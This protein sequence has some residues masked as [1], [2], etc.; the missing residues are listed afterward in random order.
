MVV[1]PTCTK[2]FLYKKKY[3]A[4]LRRGVFIK[5]NVFITLLNV[6]LFIINIIIDTQKA[7][8]LIINPGYDARKTAIKP[9]IFVSIVYS[10]FIFIIFNHHP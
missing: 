6:F 2:N 1:N 10:Y 9:I 5:T 4:A 3:P 8:K 7:K